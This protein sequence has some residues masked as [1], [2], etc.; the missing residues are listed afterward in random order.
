MSDCCSSQHKK[1]YPT[2][3][4]C[5]VNGK[6]YSSVKTRTMLH[7][8]KTPWNRTLNSQGY[9]FCSDPDCEVVYFGQDNSTFNQSEIRT[10]VGQKKSEKHSTV[11]YCFGVS[12]KLAN[13]SPEV[14]QFVFEQTQTAN[15]SCEITNPSGRCCLK[16]FPKH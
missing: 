16:D 5:P 2:A 7:H 8:L 6:K 12:Q 13:E 3:H 11:C 4:H 14:K 9:Y 15:C 10:S 1:N